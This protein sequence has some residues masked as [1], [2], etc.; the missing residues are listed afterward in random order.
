MTY[1][2]IGF[3]V[4]LGLAILVSLKQRKQ[5]QPR[6]PLELLPHDENG[7]IPVPDVYARIFQRMQAEYDARA[8]QRKLLEDQYR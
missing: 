4:W 6:N 5:S 7:G 1:L 2:A 8:L 3:I